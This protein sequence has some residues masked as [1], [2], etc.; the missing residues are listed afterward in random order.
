MVIKNVYR[1]GD[2]ILVFLRTAASRTIHG[3][4]VLLLCIK[5]ELIA[6]AACNTIR[7]D[8]HTIYFNIVHCNVEK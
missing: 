7:K 5:P 8:A 4:Y 1:T 6:L 3:G 2:K